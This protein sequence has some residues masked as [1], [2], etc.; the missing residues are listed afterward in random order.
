MIASVSGGSFTAGYSGLHG[1]RIFQDFE[2]RF[3]KNHIQ[4][5]YIRRLLLPWNWVKLARPGFDRTDLAAELYDD[6]LFE[7]ATFGDIH[8]TPAR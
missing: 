2:P 4:D 3:L 6:V 8:G 5:R 1:D 7:G